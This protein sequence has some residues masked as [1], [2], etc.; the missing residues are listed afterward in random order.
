[1]QLFAYG[2]SS[3]GNTD[4][5]IVD[6]SV[7]SRLAALSLS[8]Y[9]LTVT[10]HLNLPFTVVYSEHL[11]N[12]WDRRSTSDRDFAD[13]IR[14]ADWGKPHDFNK[15]KYMIGLWEEYKV[16]RIIDSDIQG[17]TFSKFLLDR[18]PNLLSFNST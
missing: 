4:I 3:L 10:K 8:A 6:I 18:S 2:K 14:G 12:Q 13:I 5:C 17:R 9:S 11:F 15:S 16:R 1:M 7:I